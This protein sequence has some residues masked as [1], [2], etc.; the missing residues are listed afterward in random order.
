MMIK[1]YADENF[2]QPAVAQL[3][4]LGYDVLTCYEA[5][6]ANQG[7]S[8]EEVL[9]F[10]TQQQ[11]AVIT[12]NRKHFIKLH[13]RL[14]LHAGII[15]CAEDRNDQQLAYRVHRQL[16]THTSLDNQ[17]IRINQEE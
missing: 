7:L 13:H 11:R 8:D 16:I 10:A 3:R 1:L 15:V 12:Y 4:Q 17:L 9:A 5:G 2:R 14:K 6:Q